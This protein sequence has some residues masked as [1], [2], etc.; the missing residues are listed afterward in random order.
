MW[1][2]P[3]IATLGL[4]LTIPLAMVADM[5]M[6]QRQYSVIYVLGSLGVSVAFIFLL[7]Q[8]MQLQCVGKFCAAIC[9]AYELTMLVLSL[10]V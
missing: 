5:V 6:H 4:S 10:C 2:T 3:L 9:F 8:S 7:S 1:T